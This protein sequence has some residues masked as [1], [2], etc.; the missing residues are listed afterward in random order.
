MKKTGFTEAQ[1]IVILRQMGNGLPGSG[2][3]R[4]HG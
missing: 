2:L 3:C 1:V 4:K